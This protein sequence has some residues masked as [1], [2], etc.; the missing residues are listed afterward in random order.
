VPKVIGAL[1]GLPGIIE[2]DAFYPEKEARVVDEAKS[3]IRS[4]KFEIRNKFK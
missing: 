2:T 4:S 1:A 3:K